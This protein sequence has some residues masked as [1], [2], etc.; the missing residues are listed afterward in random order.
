MRVNGISLGAIKTPNNPTAWSTPEKE[1]EILE[2]IPYG[3][4][5][6]ASDIARATVW[7]ASDDSDYMM[8]RRFIS[9]AALTLYPGS[10]SGA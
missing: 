8:V 4:L 10:Q 2:L 7:L 9:M 1:A 3:R 6:Q 5:G